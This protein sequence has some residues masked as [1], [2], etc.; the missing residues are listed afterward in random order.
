MKQGDPDIFLPFFGPAKVW[1]MGGVPVRKCELCTCGVSPERCLW[2][3]KHMHGFE[4][5]LERARQAETMHALGADPKEIA[6]Q[7][8]VRV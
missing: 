1:A 5:T 7:L 2:H 8:G 6:R 3:L 4:L